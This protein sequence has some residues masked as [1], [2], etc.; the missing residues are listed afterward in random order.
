MLLDLSTLSLGQVERV[1]EF[2]PQG[3][4]GVCHAFAHAGV[5][6]PDL[7]D[8]ASGRVCRDMAAFTGEP[9]SLHH[10]ALVSDRHLNLGSWRV[11][12][13]VCYLAD[14]QQQQLVL[15]TG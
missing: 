10:L 11:S 5:R 9:A 12:I 1:D 15:L 2:T 7:F 4:S 13:A 8:A 6:A 3:L 14:L